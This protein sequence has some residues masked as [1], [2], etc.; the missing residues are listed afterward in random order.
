M[1]CRVARLV[2]APRF[3]ADVR[4]PPPAAQDVVV[5]AAG[6]RLVRRWRRASLERDGQ[7]DA[8]A[9]EHAA[10]RGRPPAHRR[11][12][13]RDPVRRRQHAAPRRA[14][15]RRLPVRRARAPARR[16]RAA[17][18]FPD[19]DRE[20]AYRIDAPAG[21]GADRF[22]PGEYRVSR[23][24]RRDRDA[25]VELA[26]PAR[27]GRARQRR[28]DARRCAPASARTLARDAAPSYA[29]AFNSASWD[30]FDRWSEARRDQRLGVS[31]QYLPEEVQ[32]VRGRR[33][34]GTGDWRYEHSYGYVWYPRCRRA[35]GRTTT[36]AG[37]AFVRYGWTWVGADRVG[38]ADAPLRPL[39]LL[40]RRLVLDSGPKLG[41]GLGV[42]GVR[43]RTTSAGARS[44]G[45]TAPWSQLVSVPGRA[46][47]S[48]AGMDGRP[49]SPLRTRLRPRSWRQATCYPAYAARIRD[50]GQRAGRSRLRRPPRRRRRFG[51]PGPAPDAATASPVYTNL[52]P[53]GSQ[54]HWRAVTDH[55]RAVARDA[56]AGGAS[57]DA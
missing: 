29:Y 43:A 24:P 20:V 13:R 55:G 18:P 54:G 33:S 27:R 15:D 8:V 2:R 30:A 17:R 48:V 19:P 44:A 16:A 7:P 22:A 40:G 37:S 56:T 39:G 1:P 36:A 32:P 6:A 51:L 31:T 45:T 38:L 35:G 10:A 28:R 12:A 49:G 50:R 26:G 23:A 3:A 4:Q 46:L 21:V 9:R 47:R 34:I 11:R 25:E 53:G 14:H 52:E 42:V 41:A 57:S 5:G